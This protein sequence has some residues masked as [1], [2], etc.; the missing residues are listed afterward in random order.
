MVCL[1]V[2]TDVTAAGSD[3]YSAMA[4]W[5]SSELRYPVVFR[6]ADSRPVV[7]ALVIGE[8]ALRLSG[9]GV[10][11]GLVELTVPCGEIEQTRIGRAQ[12]ERINGYAT[13]VVD[14]HG[15][16]SVLIA[17]FG[18]QLLHEV[19][20]LIASLHPDDAQS[21]ERLDLIVP[22]KPGCEQRIRQLVGAG[23]PFDLDQFAEHRV[24]L[25]QD[26]IV[27]TFVGPNIQET[28][29]QTL[30]LPDLWR[31]GV[32]WRRCLSGRPHVAAPGD[33]ADGE[34]ELI[35]SWRRPEAHALHG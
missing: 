14:R 4:E 21:D 23:P 33:A 32:A 6:T 16:P 15:G 8:E 35:F 29:R 5:S 25:G 10:E 2:S 27:F 9:R 13:V 24:H 7:G 12:D 31:A 28:V 19:S 22:I 18:I 20:D 11:T 17:P 3:E 26:D 1:V 30:T 34:R